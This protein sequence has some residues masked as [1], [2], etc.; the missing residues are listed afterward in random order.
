LGVTQMS[1]K[2]YSF[3]GYVP[4]PQNHFKKM[5]GSDLRWRA[6]TLVYAYGVPVLSASRLL[7][8]SVRAISRWYKQFM[9]SYSSCVATAK[10]VIGG[11]KDEKYSQFF[12]LNLV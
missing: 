10:R 9:R 12:A 7:G 3:L 2:G 1:K 6:V 11:G 8:V 5:Y 4:A